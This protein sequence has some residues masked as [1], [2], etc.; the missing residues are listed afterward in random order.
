MLR[1]IVVAA[2]VVAVAIP[3]ATAKDKVT[4]YQVKVTPDFARQEL[5]GDEVIRLGRD[6]GAVEW[7][8]QRGLRLKGSQFSDETDNANAPETQT[9]RLPLESPG[10][11]VMRF[12][13]IASAGRGLRWL[14]SGDALFTAFYCEAWMVCDNEPGRRATLRLEIVVPAASGLTA[15][16]PG[17][18]SKE[19]TDTEGT[20]FVFEQNEP[21]QTYLFSFGVAKMEAMGQGMQ[22]LYAKTGGHAVALR[23]TAEAYTFLR[24]KAGVGLNGGAYRQ[25]FLPMAKAGFG[26][27][28]A[29]L[30]LMS[31]EYLAN[32]EKND[33]VQLMAHEMAHQW[34][35]VL[36]GV[37]SWSD[38][39]LNEGMA[40]FMSDVYLEEHQGKPAYERQMAENESRLK[41]LRENGKDRPLHWEG[42]KDAH[43]ALGP[44]PYVK[45]TLF[46]CRLR[47]E[48]GEERFWR[49]IATYTK[50]NAG[51]LVGTEDFE[52]AM[53]EA[54]GRNLKAMFQNEVYR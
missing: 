15:A 35:G 52:R 12:E 1:A 17:R 48:L 51:K 31:E 33:D 19:F 32:L 20:H 37:R 21:V 40:E 34:W 23:K 4:H 43:E 30:G 6:A 47:K 25:A 16:G 11:H 2:S 28:A 8:K 9:L 41:E 24:S 10:K 45:G 26:Q 54:S 46:L 42:W 53:E 29:G 18:L 7:K 50:R 13:Y 38:F 5:H 49:G 27:E 14:G 36:V 39:W 3:A 22:Q 44:I